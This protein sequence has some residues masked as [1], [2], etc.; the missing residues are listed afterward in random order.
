LDTR[1]QDAWVR[2]HLRAWMVMQE[3]RLFGPG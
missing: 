2:S 3:R 1:A